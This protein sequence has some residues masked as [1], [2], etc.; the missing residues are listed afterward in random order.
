M[1]D[2]SGF[3][4]SG[5]GPGGRAKDSRGVGGWGGG[6]GNGGNRSGGRLLSNQ[7]NNDKAAREK[8]AR[9]KAAKEQAAKEKAAREKAAQEAAAREQRQAEERQQ[10]QRAAAE[11]KHGEDDPRGKSLGAKYSTPDRKSWAKKHGVGFYGDRNA[12]TSETNNPHGTYGDGQADNAFSKGVA[13]SSLGSMGAGGKGNGGGVAPQ[14]PAAEARE[15]DAKPFDLQAGL[16]ELSDPKTK[17][18]PGHEAMKAGNRHGDWTKNE[19]GQWEFEP[20]RGLLGSLRD[21][22]FGYDRNVSMKAMVDQARRSPKHAQTFAEAHA[23]GNMMTENGKS[24][25]DKVGVAIDVAKPFGSLLTGN[26]AGAAYGAFNAVDTLRDMAML[27]GESSESKQQAAPSRT[28]RGRVSLKGESDGNFGRLLRPRAGGGG[29]SGKADEAATGAGKVR[30]ATRKG[31]KRG[32]GSLILT[33]RR[34]LEDGPVLLGGRY[35]S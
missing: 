12:P 11:A 27:D 24:A 33:G 5:F 32:K 2:F 9:E 17:W 3:S 18:A 19:E 20:D 29:G 8:A 6:N 35:A 1:P 14:P 25:V 22:V 28:A 16:R 21:S 26:F 31:P 15:E 23:E 13:P 34:G 4:G 10:A 30:G 7:R